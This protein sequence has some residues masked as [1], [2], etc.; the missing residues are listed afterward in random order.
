[1]WLWEYKGLKNGEF[2]HLAAKG[3]RKPKNGG[4]SP[5]CAQNTKTL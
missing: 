2:V 4:F 1:M 3:V 5:R